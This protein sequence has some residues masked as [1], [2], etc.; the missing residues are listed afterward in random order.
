MGRVKQSIGERGSLKWI[1]KAIN[2]TP[3]RKLDELILPHLKGAESIAWSSPL[4]SDSHAEYRDAAFLEKIGASK[5]VSKLER[6]WPE[7]GPQ[8]DALGQS[9]KGDILLVEAKAHIDEICSPPTGAGKSSL[10]RIKRAL[11]KTETY[12]RA[13]PRAKWR[14]VF[15]Q[16]TNR[17]AHLYFLR[18]H[19]LEAWLILVNFIGDNEMRGPSSPQEW[20][21]AYKIV[22]H[23]LGIEARNPLSKYVVHVFPSVSDFAA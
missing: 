1:Q 13:K 21:A 16:L 2:Q 17:L 5:L 23:V 3:P 12:V 7:R 22:W 20:E 19:G 18:K 6:F 8:W 4:S 11:A 15:Y 14:E 9:N 10:R